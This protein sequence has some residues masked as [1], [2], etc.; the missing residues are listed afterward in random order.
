MKR[1]GDTDCSFV[2]FRSRSQFSASPFCASIAVPTPPPETSPMRLALAALFALAVPAAAQ[3]HIAKSDAKSPAD[4]QKSFK[5][6]PGFEAQLVA[7]EPDIGKPIQIAFDA[8]GRLWLT[9]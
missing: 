9:T 1:A 5:L 4:E 2:T 7:S 8:K 6:P 3:E